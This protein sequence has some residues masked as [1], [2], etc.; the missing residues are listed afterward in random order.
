M[1]DNIN[2]TYLKVCQMSIYEFINATKACE[3]RNLQ[4]K[5]LFIG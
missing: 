3:L 5:V 2:S 4:K 1:G